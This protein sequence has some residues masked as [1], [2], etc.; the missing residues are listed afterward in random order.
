MV[1]ASQRFWTICVPQLMLT[2]DDARDLALSHGFSAAWSE[3]LI[4]KDGGVLGTFAIYYPH[5]EPECFDRVFLRWLQDGFAGR[6]PRID[7]I[8][9]AYMYV[10]A[11]V[12]AANQHNGVRTTF[13]SLAAIGSVLAASSCCLPILPFMMAA[14]LAGTSTFLSAARPYLDFSGG[15]VRDNPE[16]NKMVSAMTALGRPGVPDDVGPLIAALLSDENRWVNDRESKSPAGWHCKHSED[17]IS[18]TAS[19][20]GTLKAGDGPILTTFSPYVVQ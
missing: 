16:V 10:G 9:I 8:G 13:A 7:R 12:K 20:G 6:T 1:R 17:V 15:I 18:P 2:P 4:S 11:W 5:D 19:A 14:G 3:P